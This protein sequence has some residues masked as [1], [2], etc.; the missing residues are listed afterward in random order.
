MS[1]TIETPSPEVPVLNFGVLLLPDYQWLDAAGSVDYLNQHSYA[2]FKLFRAPPHLLAQVPIMKWHYLSSTG[3]L[4]D[5][6][7]SSGPP[8]R[9][10]TTFAECPELDYLVVPG[11]A[12]P[13]APLSEECIQFVQERFPKLKG[14][15]T[16]CTGSLAM[17]QTGVLD[18]VQAA[19]NK[20]VL[21]MLAT[22]GLLNRKV[23]WVG[24]RRF[25]V[26]GKVWT[27]AGVTAGI[28]LAAEWARV[29]FSEEVVKLAQDVSEYVPNPAKP[30]PF[31]RLL[32][33]I[34]LD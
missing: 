27:S 2:M 7:A 9:P 16:I 5:V 26:D 19:G 8:S 25:V 14:F 28:D 13:T 29:Q 21:R 31:A 20:Y 32:E 18:G 6:P 10:T 1:S 34:K 33:G 12:D 30:D 4:E 15:L 23:K 17:A 11:P 3:D 24:D 22:S